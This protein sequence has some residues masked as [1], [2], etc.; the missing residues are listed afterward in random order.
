MEFKQVKNVHLKRGL[1]KTKILGNNKPKYGELVWL[2]ERGS[3][4]V[5]ASLA[6]LLEEPH[7]LAAAVGAPQVAATRAVVATV[8]GAVVT[9]APP[10][11][12]RSSININARST[13]EKS[14]KLRT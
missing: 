1:N 12:T 11:H 7:T 10:P 9:V 3:L 14:E 5:L 4:R 13:S 6:P 2:G 8:A